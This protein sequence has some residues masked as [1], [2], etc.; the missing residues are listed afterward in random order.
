MGMLTIVGGAIALS[1]TTGHTSSIRLHTTVPFII[2][3]LRCSF[4]GLVSTE[5]GGVPSL[6][7]PLGRV[8]RKRK[9]DEIPRPREIRK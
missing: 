4:S 5:R 3:R 1:A 2:T 7:V 6:R 9:E 8:G